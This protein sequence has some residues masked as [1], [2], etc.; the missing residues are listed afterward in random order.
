MAYI[1]PGAGFAAAGSVLVLLGTFLLAIGVVL[2]YP[3][4]VLL[5]LLTGRGGAKAKVK[6]VV[7]V[8]LDGF[9][10]GLAKQYMDEGR[11]PNFKAL[12]EEGHFSPLG[13]SCPSISP[14]ATS[15][16]R[17]VVPTATSRFLN[18]TPGVCSTSSSTARCTDRRRS[19]ARLRASPRWGSMRTS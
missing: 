14:V 1:G 10:P 3:L 19:P 13:T 9:D 11:M 2:L 18:R 8:G 12:G 4:K 15:T 6:K 5:R 17:C 16:G 7:V